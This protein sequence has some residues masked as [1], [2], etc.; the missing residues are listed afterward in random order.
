VC[1][2]WTCWSRRASERGLFTRR[3]EELA[4]AENTAIVLSPNPPG[5]LDHFSASAQAV[6]DQ[7]EA[8]DSFHLGEQPCETH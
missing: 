6:D 2:V 5:S 3:D 8:A 7:L 1:A 4:P